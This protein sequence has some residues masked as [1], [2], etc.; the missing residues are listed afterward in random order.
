MLTQRSLSADCYWPVSCDC[1]CAPWS[2]LSD[3]ISH[4]T[5]IQSSELLQSS[6]LC[7]GEYDTLKY[8]RTCAEIYLL[9]FTN[10]D[11]A[12][13]CEQIT[14]I[15]KITWDVFYWLICII[16]MFLLLANFTYWDVFLLANFYLLACFFIGQMFLLECFYWPFFVVGMLDITTTRSRRAP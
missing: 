1:N 10:W 14:P 3:W 6:T 5:D 16:V 15:R 7:F 4:S 9:H 13:L 8:F 2:L 11:T 12:H